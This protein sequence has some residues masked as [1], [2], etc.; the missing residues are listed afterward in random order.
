MSKDF[1]AV[2]S[3]ITTIFNADT[4][5][6][7]NVNALFHREAH[8]FF[9]HKLIPSHNGWEFMHI[10]TDTMSQTVIEVLSIAS[11]FDDLAGSGIYLSCCNTLFNKVN[12]CLMCFKAKIIHVDLELVGLTDSNCSCHITS[13]A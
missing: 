2:F 1:K 6:T 12:S 3:D 8:A 4:N 7:C 9:N 11:F 5:F 10:H 13:V